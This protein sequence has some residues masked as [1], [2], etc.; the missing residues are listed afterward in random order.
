MSDAVSIRPAES[1]EVRACGR[2]LYEAF[3]TIAEKHNFPPEVPSEEVGIG[4]SGQ[5][6]GNPGFYCVV[7]E[8]GGRIVG[9]NC[10]DERNESS[11][12]GPISVDPGVQD[13]GIGRKLMLAVIDRSNERGFRGVRLVQDAYHCRSLSLY[14]KLDFACREQLVVMN[15]VPGGEDRSYTVRP[16][17]DADATTCNRL[18]AA[19]HGF[20]RDGEL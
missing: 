10:L 17:T 1:R 18:C 7:G 16:A 12:I 14:A 13:S 4:I 6:F 20:N 15:G 2:I 8:S 19:T 3:R 11:G 9:S 5:L